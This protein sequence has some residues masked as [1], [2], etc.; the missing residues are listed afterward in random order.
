MKFLTSNQETKLA[1]LCLMLFVTLFFG[2]NKPLRAQ[3]N[4]RELSFD[5][6]EDGKGING[7]RVLVFDLKAN[8]DETVFV[9]HSE[10]IDIYVSF[11]N[12][13][14]VFEPTLSV[15]KRKESE[16]T[17]LTF[18]KAGLYNL[19]FTCKNRDLSQVNRIK[20]IASN[21]I[22]KSNISID[23]RYMTSLLVLSDHLLNDL[24]SSINRQMDFLRQRK[25]YVKDSIYNEKRRIE[26]EL[27]QL[28]RSWSKELLSLSDKVESLHLS[29]DSALVKAK[30]RRLKQDK[31]E[32]YLD[33]ISNLKTAHR[34]LIESSKVNY[35]TY[36]HNRLSLNIER[37]L[38]RLINKVL[39]TKSGY[40]IRPNKLDKTN[41]LRRQYLSI[42][43]D[44]LNEL[45]SF[46][47]LLMIE[48]SFDKDYN[49]TINY[50]LFEKID[51]LRKASK[52]L[53]YELDSLRAII[54]IA[55]RMKINQINRL[56]NRI[57][58]LS[59]RDPSNYE[60][61]SHRLTELLENAPLQ[62]VRQLFNPPPEPTT[63]KRI[64][65]NQ[66]LINPNFW[67]LEQDIS[68]HLEEAEY[69]RTRVLHTEDGFTIITADERFDKEGK[70]LDIPERYSDTKAPLKLSSLSFE[71][72][73]DRFSNANKLYH[74]FFIIQ[75]SQDG[76][77]QFSRIAKNN[78]NL[79]QYR[80]G[81]DN[82]PA[83]A[84]SIPQNRSRIDVNSS[85]YLKVFIY[86]FTRLDTQDTA[87]FNTRPTVPIDVHLKE[88]EILHVIEALNK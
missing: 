12:E 73:I 13:S 3:D 61:L 28:E 62:R 45:E 5:F 59:Y 56:T 17:F 50:E 34:A 54:D 47:S 22:A 23:L 25:R 76:R 67:S 70:R 51:S 58:R 36:I 69:D 14:A 88:S 55:D 48:S 33:T 46:D 26:F 6:I 40:G 74:R 65:L 37:R 29:F 39:P 38:N 52:Y 82:M 4:S 53:L 2:I 79:A 15:K 8:A 41:K 20:Y 27:K 60:I 16:G 18:R 64:I 83:Y 78:N 80:Q 49:L 1:K 71:K 32:Q 75:V 30:R 7:Y 9:S 42:N 21:V 66:G 31:E 85:F 63:S 86:E 87:Y 72:F 11:N 68:Y 35:R 43:S 77:K 57:S 81:F 10:H 84:Q 44:L 24:D 19:V